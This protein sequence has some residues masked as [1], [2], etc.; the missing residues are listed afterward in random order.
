MMAAALAFTLASASFKANAPMPAALAYNRSG[1][2]GRN[3]SPE[4]HWSGEPANTRSFALVMHDPD[5][6]APG[7]WFHWVVYN[8]PGSTHALKAGAPLP[9][10][11]LGTTSW[12]ER[13]YGGPCPPPGNAHHYVFTLYALDTPKIAGRNPTGPQLEALVSRHTLARATLIGTF[14]R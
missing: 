6:P 2:T 12:D 4:L 1:C 7:G 10:D 14:A 8:I 11:E 9:Q 5:A 3:L 13:G